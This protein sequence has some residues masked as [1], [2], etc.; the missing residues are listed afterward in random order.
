M[1][2]RLLKNE[3]RKGGGGKKKGR[4]KEGRRKEGKERENSQ[5]PTKLVS[6]LL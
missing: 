4:K 5:R 6:G 3:I 1:L 2:Q